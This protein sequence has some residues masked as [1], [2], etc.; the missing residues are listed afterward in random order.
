MKTWLMRGEALGTWEIA[1]RTRLAINEPIRASVF[2]EGVPTGARKSFHRALAA[3]RKSAQ[4]Q[5]AD[6]PG[7][8]NG[9]MTASFSSTAHASEGIFI[10]WVNSAKSLSDD[11]LRPSNAPTAKS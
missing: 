3:M 9:P 4:F 7:I 10:V 5:Q 1:S 11:L 6:S 2:P 8:V